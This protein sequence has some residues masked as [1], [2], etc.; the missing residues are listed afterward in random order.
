MLTGPAQGLVVMEF[1]QSRRLHRIEKTD[2]PTL[3]VER[4]PL[5]RLGWLARFD[6]TDSIHPTESCV[7]ALASVRRTLHRA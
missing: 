7:G 3:L 6:P 2:G 5:I 4:E 1:R